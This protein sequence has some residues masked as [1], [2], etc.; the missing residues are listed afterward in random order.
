MRL[1]K[2]LATIMFS[3]LLAC[4]VIGCEQVSAQTADETSSAAVQKDKKD[5]ET[6]LDTQLYLLVASN[7]PV[8]DT[9]LP[10]TL[11][12]LIKQLRMSLPFK[13][14]RLAATL[15][16][17]VKSEGHLSLR[18]IGGPLMAT[19]AASN[20]T[21]SFNEFKVGRVR[22]AT[23]AA[24]QTVVRMEGFIFGARI[25]IQSGTAIA[26]NGPAAP[27]INYENTGLNTDISM[28]EGEP[29]IVGTLNVGPS[30]D[31]IILVMSARRTEK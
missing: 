16:N 1:R 24:G 10:G 20:A 26:S 3:T 2:S 31:A 30:G 5:D 21:P 13:N 12:P 27:I 15:L 6:N 18:W 7:N 28:R 9:K 23:N 14:Y 11:D 25:P 4:F 22:V 8:E 29:V 17:R 19:A